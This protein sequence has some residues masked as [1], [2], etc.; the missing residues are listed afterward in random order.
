MMNLEEEKK[1]VIEPLPE[2]VASEPAKKP[3][4]RVTKPKKEK[5][6]THVMTDKRRIALEN[7]RVKKRQIAAERKAAAALQTNLSAPAQSTQGYSYGPQYDPNAAAATSYQH[8]SQPSGYPM[9]YYPPDSRYLEQYEKITQ[10]ETL[11][12]KL[13]ADQQNS[14]L[15]PQSAPPQEIA[16]V[17]P[18]K[19]IVHN[20][21]PYLSRRFGR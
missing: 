1:I 15:V 8:F 10:V 9:Q 2:Q 19:H 17:E 18:E 14:N 20:P 13:L 12:N 16:R 21:N 7:A 4:A 11:L 3:K 5:V 6:E